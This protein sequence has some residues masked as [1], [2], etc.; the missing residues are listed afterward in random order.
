M[1]TKENWFLFFCL[2]VHIVCLFISYASPICTIMACSQH[3]NWTEPI[4]S[5]SRLQFGNWK[6]VC[7][8]WTLLS[9]ADV[10][11]LGAF[12]QKCL[13]Q[14]LWIRWY[15]RVRNDEALQRTGLT[16]LSHLLSRRRI[17]VLGHLAR[18][19]DDTPANMALQLYVNVYRSTDLLTTHGVSHAPDD[20]D[21]VFRT[22]C[23]PTDLVF[24]AA[25]QVVKL[26]R[27]TNE[28]CNRVDCCQAVQFSRVSRWEGLCL[29]AHTSR[30]LPISC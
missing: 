21:D 3:I 5:S 24:A 18:L 10:R 23:A 1:H 25:C 27:V 8:D 12:R 30:L 13:R 6:C 20:D 4:V 19:D 17:S 28:L 11:T 22:D 7:W 14:L 9:A 16:S 26:R 2:T 29:L 15:D